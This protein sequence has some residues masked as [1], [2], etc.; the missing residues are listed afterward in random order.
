MNVRSLLADRFNQDVLWNIGSLGMLAVGGIVVNLI[1]IRFRGEDALGIFNQVYAIYI[2]LSQIGVGGLQHSTL[3]HVSHNQDDRSRCADITTSALI[4]VTV[5]TLPTMGIASLFARPIGDVLNSSGVSQ[6]LILV[7]PG[8]LFF[9]L[10]KVLINALNGLQRMRAYAVFRA[11]RFILIPLAVI[12]LVLLDTPDSSLPLALTVSEAVL[13]AALAAYVYARLLPL[14]PIVTPR[15]RFGEHLSFGVRGVLSGILTELNTRVDVLM[16][17]YF[18]TDA[19]VGIYSFAAMLAEGVGQLPLAVRWNVDPILGRYFAAEAASKIAETARHIRRT[20][21]PVM[22][23]AGVCA[24]LLYPVMLL[25]WSDDHILASWTVFSII[26][27]GVTINAGYRP[28]TGILLQGG[29]PGT[30]TAFIT[31]LVITDA[32]LNLLFIPWLGIYGAAIVTAL[33]YVFEAA[34]TIVF[35]RRL[36]GVRL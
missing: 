26:M 3:K 4:L 29:H 2:V 9:A 27:L 21:Y 10:N 23:V 8:L 15:D 13:F 11:L 34:G 33:T 24:V 30:H 32:L 17:G 12:G 19:N 18:T 25:I 16:L 31:G 36:F 1:I 20:F 22:A 28:F 7:L 35:A 14:K 5:I 6:G